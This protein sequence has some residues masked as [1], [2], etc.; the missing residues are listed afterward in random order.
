MKKIFS[1]NTTEVFTK[2]VFHYI[3]EILKYIDEIKDPRKQ[4]NYSMRYLIFSEI[5]MFLSEG[6]S[7]RYTETAYKDNKYLEN[8]EK[9]INQKVEKIPDAEIYTDVFS[10]IRGLH[11]VF[12]DK[13]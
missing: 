13:Y 8:I 11:N 7:Q 10:K 2:T 4:Y 6:K 3:P 12:L 1:N 9:I 5:M